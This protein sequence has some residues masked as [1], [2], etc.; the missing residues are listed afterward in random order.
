LGFSTSCVLAQLS[1]V[2]GQK[3]KRMIKNIEELC[4]DSR[5]WA[6]QVESKHW[7]CKGHKNTGCRSVRQKKD[8]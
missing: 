4:L 1:L 3:M 8:E 7:P 6:G 5:R 2:F